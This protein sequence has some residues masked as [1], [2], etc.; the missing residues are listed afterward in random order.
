MKRFK[1]SFT[2]L[3]VVF[4]LA[5]AFTVHK[6][7]PVEWVFSGSDE[8]DWNQRVDNTKYTQLSKIC[9]PG[10]EEFC[11]MIA[12]DINPVDGK[13]DILPTTSTLYIN[14]KNNQESLPHP[15]SNLIYLEV[16]D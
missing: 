6:Y 5:S 8:T 1:M 14:L 7:T 3:A 15:I 11:K 12:G 2:L 13:P 4:A 9:S 10:D 16:T